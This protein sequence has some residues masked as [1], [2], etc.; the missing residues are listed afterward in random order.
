MHELEQRILSEAEVIGHGLLRVDGFLNHQ[1]DPELIDHCGRDLAQA[2]ATTNPT[3]V[4]TVESAG[5]A[6]ALTTA[7]H[8]GVPM[9]FARTTMPA[10]MRTDAWTTQAKSHTKGHLVTLHIARDRL[11]TGQRVLIVD[12]FLGSGATIL[13]LA[14]LV[15]AAG[16]EL[17]GVGVLIEKTFE[18]GRADLAALGVPVVSLARVA[19]LTGGVI[20]LGD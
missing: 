16:A 7:L 12:D 2:L 5:I 11:T 10:T 4:L 6:P 3:K 8:L 15:R 1:I 20:H 9:L 19:A 18:G 14:E 17:V 13:A